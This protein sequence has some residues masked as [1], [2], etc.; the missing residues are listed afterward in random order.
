MATVNQPQ[1][2]ATAPPPFQTGSAIQPVYAT[3][4]MKCYPITDSELKQLGLA[5][6][7]MTATFGAGSACFAFALDIFKDTALAGSVPPAADVLVNAIQPLGY[8]FGA[9]FW[10]GSIVVWIWRR[11]MIQT[12]KD[13]SV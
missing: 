2:P 4:N 3:R 8:V 12:I 1:P 6:I 7:A 11:N 10:V 9:A 13:E 5:N